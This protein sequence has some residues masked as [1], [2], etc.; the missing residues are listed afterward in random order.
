M[1]CLACGHY[2]QADR[3]MARE[4]GSDRCPCPCHKRPAPKPVTP[5]TLSRAGGKD[6]A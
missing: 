4:Q 2:S 6:A 1:I 3:E 5:W